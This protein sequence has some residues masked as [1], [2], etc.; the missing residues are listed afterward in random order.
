[1]KRPEDVGCGDRCSL[2]K[3][4]EWGAGPWETEPD[5]VDFEHAGFPCLLH[6]GGLGHWCGY[7]GLP[8]GH[9]LFGLDYEIPDVDVHGGLTY[10]EVCAGHICHVPKPGE[11]DSRWWFGFD[12]GHAFDLSPG[13]ILAEGRFLTRGRDAHY[14]DVTYVRQQTERLAEQLKAITRKENT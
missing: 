2:Q 13:L 14:R 5:R 6:R 10:A 12:C 11:S 1:M 8:S 9:P 7:V 4:D 3:R